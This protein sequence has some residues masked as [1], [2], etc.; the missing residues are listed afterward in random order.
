MS[1]H[2]HKTPRTHHPDSATHH[3]FMPQTTPAQFWSPCRL[4]VGVN[5]SIFRIDKVLP[6]WNNMLHKVPSH[7]KIPGLVWNETCWA[8][9]HS[10]G[11]ARGSW[12]CLPHG[13]DGLPLLF[14][15]YTQDFLTW[16]QYPLQQPELLG[17]H[18]H[19]FSN[20]VCASIMYREWRCKCHQQ[21]KPCWHCWGFGLT[22]GSCCWT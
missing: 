22:G 2:T 9:T 6:H 16:P 8:H 5:G 1:T 12:L 10:P 3:P 19:M 15:I 13:W 17:L 7:H 4:W 21:V 11:L 18:P 20:C 14:M